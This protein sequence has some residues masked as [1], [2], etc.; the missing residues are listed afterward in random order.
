MVGC[1]RYVS[2]VPSSCSKIISLFRRTNLFV[3]AFCC[4]ANRSC[5]CVCVCVRSCVCVCE[6][7]VCVCVLYYSL[8]PLSPSC[9]SSFLLLGRYLL[10]P[11]LPPPFLHQQSA[12]A[13]QHL[14]SPHDLRQTP[15]HKSVRT[16]VARPF[17]ISLILFQTSY[18]AVTSTSKTCIFRKLSTKTRLFSLTRV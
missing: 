10:P 3:F 17:R 18:I 16:L 13:L 7:C 15:W 5:V 6:Q 12:R 2:K 8:S 11:P 9:P 14:V 1:H 4:A